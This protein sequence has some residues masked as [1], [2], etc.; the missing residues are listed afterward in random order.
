[1]PGGTTNPFLFLFGCARSGTTLL[2]RMLDAHPEVAMG[3]RFGWLATAYKDDVGV[4]ADG[5]LTPAFI[6]EFER[7]PRFFRPGEIPLD[8]EALLELGR[9]SYAEFVSEIL[10]RYGDTRGKPHVGTKTFPLVFDFETVHRLWPRTKVIHIVR[11]GRDTAL[12]LLEWRRADKMW[13]F[14][15][16]E[17]DPVGTAALWWEWHVRLVQDAARIAGP[18]RFY[19]IRYESLV[20]QPQRE[21]GALCEFLGLP[22][23]D[24]MLRYYEGRTRDDPSLDAKH[25]WLPPI[26]GLRDWRSQM[27]PED[28]ERFEAVAGG[29]LEELGYPLSCSPSAEA[30]SR[31][32][33]L[34]SLFV[35]EGPV[36]RAWRRDGADVNSAAPTKSAGAGRG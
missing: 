14:A 26:V 28:V 6:E 11:D 12:S 17:H 3:P 22:Y 30:R 5:S 36:P 16:W 19:E 2:V 18:E 20:S 35:P 25:A 32:A 4:T 29:L 8:R 10:D 33:W 31:A 1:M 13:R 34:R 7:R 9:L 21:L 27:P 15:T 24:A 23:D